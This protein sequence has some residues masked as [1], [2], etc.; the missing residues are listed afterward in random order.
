MLLKNIVRKVCFFVFLVGW[1]E[2]VEDDAL[3]QSRI[4]TKD[5]ENIVVGT[6]GF[7][8][9]KGRGIFRLRKEIFCS[10]VDCL[11]DAT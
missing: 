5:R 4:D 2:V 10:K 3:F 1:L 7:E 9:S 11:P 8:K 6:N